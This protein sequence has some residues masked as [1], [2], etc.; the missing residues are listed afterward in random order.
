MSTQPESAAPPEP[1]EILRILSRRKRMLI[2]PW[3]IAIA[4]GVA[5]ALLLPPVY[6]SNVTLLLERPQVLSGSLNTMVNPVDP[7]RQA[8][9]MRDQV[10]SSVFL[11]GVVTATGLKSDPGD[12]GVGGA[13][14]GV[15]S[16]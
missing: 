5:A 14:V 12:A 7:E 15:V 9:I 2:V 10:Q 8:D 3:L 16:G 11:R 6:M 4:L 13:P 1:R